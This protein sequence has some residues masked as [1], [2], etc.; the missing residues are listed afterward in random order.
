MR[1]IAAAALTILTLAF[2]CLY[3]L[4]KQENRYRKCGRLNNEKISI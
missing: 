4:G 3:Q 1:R 2:W